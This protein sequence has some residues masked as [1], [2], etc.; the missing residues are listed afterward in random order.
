M[1]K[2]I[3]VFC[4]LRRKELE[5]AKIIHTEKIIDIILKIFDLM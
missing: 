3:L 2:F 4:S 5:I 1:P